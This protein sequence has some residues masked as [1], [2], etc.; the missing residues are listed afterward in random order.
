MSRRRDRGAS[1]EPKRGRAS[2]ARVSRGSEEDVWKGLTVTEPKRNEAEHVTVTVV[3]YNT[4][5][6][7]VPSEQDVAAAVEDMEALYTGCSWDGHLADDGADFMKA[8]L[9]VADMGKIAG[10][11]TTQPYK[12]PSAVVVGSDAFPMDEEHED[13]EVL[14]PLLEHD[15][16]VCD[17]TEQII[18][19]NRYHKKGEDYDLCEAEFLKLP[20]EQKVLFEVI[21]YP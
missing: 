4:V 17:V 10:K 14:G 7:G 9:T 13:E 1:P 16:V 6:G 21:A 8:E 5:A 12:P 18:A 3:L 11:V 20:T 19:G 2:A 15:N